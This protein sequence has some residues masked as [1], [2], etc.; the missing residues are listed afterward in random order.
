M[1]TI[2]ESLVLIFGILSGVVLYYQ[3]IYN[4]LFDVELGFFMLLF[5]VYFAIIVKYGN[6]EIVDEKELQIKYLASY[7]TLKAFIISIGLYYLLGK[8]FKTY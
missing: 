3:Q 1:N 6:S 4:Y 5:M 8:L 2:E 7:R